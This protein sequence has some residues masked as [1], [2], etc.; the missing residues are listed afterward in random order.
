MK[1]GGVQVVG[2]V[3]HDF[4]QSIYF[5]DPNGLR[6]E[7]TAR[8]ERPGFLAEAASEAHEALAAWMQLK[9]ANA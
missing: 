6:L 2:M 8:T 1:P 9:Q 5:F 4:I 3:D 7:I